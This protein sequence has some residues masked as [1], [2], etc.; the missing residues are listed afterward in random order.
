[1]SAQQYCYLLTIEGI[2]S[3]SGQTRYC[4]PAVPDYASALA[5][6]VAGLAEPPRSV[7]GQWDVLGQEISCGRY[8]VVL[9]RGKGPV[10][11]L[12]TDPVP[13]GEIREDVD[14]AEVAIDLSGT[15]AALGVSVDDVLYC[16]RESWLVT[17]AAGGATSCTVTRA[18]AGSSAQT[19]PWGSDIYRVPPALTG[20]LVTIYRAPREGGGAGDEFAVSYGYVSGEVAT[21]IHGATIEVQDRFVL[22]ELG[23]DA[24]PVAYALSGQVL[25]LLAIYSADTPTTGL[26]PEP[27]GIPGATGGYWLLEPAGVVVSCDWASGE[28]SPVRIYE[29]A[30]FWS[31]DDLATVR[32][33]GWN[34]PLLGERTARPIL[35]SAE[36]GLHPSFG[37]ADVATVTWAASDHPCVIA[38][39][40]L[41]SSADGANVGLTDD[42][43]YDCGPTD[44]G[45]GGGLYPDWSLGVPRAQVDVK[46]FEAAMGGIL[47]GLH[48]PHYWLSAGD[49]VSIRDA[50]WRLFAPLGY[51]CGCGRDGRWTLLRLHDAYADATMISVPALYRPAETSTAVIARA[52]DTI[53]L[54]VEADPD[55]ESR[56]EVTIDE[57]T[58][59]RYYPPHVGERVDWRP[60]PYSRGDYLDE[61]RLYQ[62]MSSVIRRMATRYTT[63]TCYLR[64]DDYD[65]VELGST[66]EIGDPAV[67]DPRTGT[68]ASSTTP[69]YALVMAVE[70]DW[71]ER[72]LQV[73]AIVLGSLRP[74]IGPACLCE[75][76][77][78]GGGLFEIQCPT[79]IYSAGYWYSRGLSATGGDG[80]T[81]VVGDR[82][83]ACDSHLV[84]QTD[85]TGAAVPTVTAVTATTVEL[86]MGFSSAG[87]AVNP[88]GM[89]IV[90]ADYDD[91]P[92]AATEIHAWVATGG[93]PTT[94]ATVGTGLDPAYRIGD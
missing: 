48:A 58:G 90:H 63:I 65:S 79:V 41:L 36:W 88:V 51:V 16:E 57:V 61:G 14:L 75:V 1:M 27:I 76:W 47:S 37:R 67:C 31:R 4:W 60:L 49:G 92:S 38:L 89:I 35:W 30:A 9:H 56:Q 42:Y 62:L 44:T 13:I 32:R 55:G 3:S 86:D 43:I 6:Y 2:G 64:A 81:F 29:G 54:G 53:A 77:N 33:D 19:H 82:V 59:R 73:T 52:L 17:V 28:W 91:C 34:G 15:C 45:S 66:L 68:R 20:R 21:G 93:D 85:T 78:T 94:A 23:G 25:Q 24:P 87:V 40:L 22:G 83:V 5:H 18:Y 10:I 11:W 84:P 70:A 69:V 72:S 39:C 50:L 71:Y 74:T 8:S 7:T 12:E 26:V 80:L 46:A